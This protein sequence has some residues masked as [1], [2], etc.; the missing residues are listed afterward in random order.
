MFNF[1]YADILAMHDAS[2]LKGVLA[3]SVDGINF[4]P[5]FLLGASVLMEVPIA[6]VLLSRILKFNA[7]RWTNIIAG[8]FMAL[9]QTTSLFVGSSPTPSYIFFSAIEITTL[10]YIVWAAWKW[11]ELKNN[12]K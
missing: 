6:M 10:L 12:K 2:Y 1:A 5:E 3:G 7:N 9:V 8:A 4:T 11:S